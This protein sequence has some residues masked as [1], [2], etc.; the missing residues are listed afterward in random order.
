MAVLFLSPLA[1]GQTPPPA[2]GELCT[3]IIEKVRVNEL[4]DFKVRY[5][6]LF[7]QVPDDT[8]LPIT[9]VIENAAPTS[10]F[11]GLKVYGEKR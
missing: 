9:E 3:K 7:P 8:F 11:V 6:K 2:H 4:Y 10:T 5:D 1:F